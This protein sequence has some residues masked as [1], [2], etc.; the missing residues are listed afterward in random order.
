MER[1]AATLLLL[2]G[3]Y[4]MALLVAKLC[5]GELIRS[6]M[7]LFTAAACTEAHWSALEATT[8]SEEDSK[9]SDGTIGVW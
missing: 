7:M 6:T 3:I 5:T 9:C 8:S 1:R 2:W 4:A